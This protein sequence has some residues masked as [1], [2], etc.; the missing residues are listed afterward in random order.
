MP[1][2]QGRIYYDA[3][4]HVM[5]T[6]DWIFDYADAMT[7]ALLKPLDLAKAG[8]MVDH[9]RTSAADRDH[10]DEVDLE[11]GRL[12][13]GCRLRS[14]STPRRQKATHDISACR[15]NHTVPEDSRSSHRFGQ[16]VRIGQEFRGADSEQTQ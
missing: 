5:E 3:D 12:P 14:A 13:S 2:A 6:A 9:V 16:N 8:K 1:Y 7:S 11:N 15:R 10:W 4:A